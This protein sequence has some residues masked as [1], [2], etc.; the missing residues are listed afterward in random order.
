MNTD[1]NSNPVQ[2]PNRQKLWANRALLVLIIG[3]AIGFAVEN[4]FIIIGCCIGLGIVL[5]YLLGRII[6]ENRVNRA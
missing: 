4:L 5:G 6:K 3:A 2:K 1:L